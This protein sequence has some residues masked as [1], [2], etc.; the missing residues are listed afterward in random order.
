MYIIVYLLCDFVSIQKMV[1][2]RSG[3]PGNLGLGHSNN[4]NDPVGL[5]N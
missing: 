5:Y 2:S 4:I 1:D 3:D